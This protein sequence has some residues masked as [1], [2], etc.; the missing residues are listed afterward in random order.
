MALQQKINIKNRRASFEYEFIDKFVAGL[1]L[2]GTEIKSIR[3]GKA[4]LSDAY[5]YFSRG[6]LYVKNLHIA[7]YA[8]GTHYNHETRRER[9]LLLNKKELRKLERKTKE[10][11]LTIIPIRLFINDRGLAKL[12]IALAKGKKLHDKRET[13]KRKDA[14][15]EMD[16]MKKM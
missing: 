3:L 9:K 12:E 14:K 5:C 8:W 7:E 15:R 16:R 2:L 4:G 11:G 10:S 1:V 6:E 13:L